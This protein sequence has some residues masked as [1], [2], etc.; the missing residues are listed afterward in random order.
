MEY[1]MD[2]LQNKPA[3]LKN[4][5][6]GNVEFASEGKAWNRLIAGNAKMFS[7][8]RVDDKE[9]TYLGANL[10]LVI[11]D[12][13]PHTS[14]VI[15]EGTYGAPDSKM[16]CMSFDGDKPA[17]FV[18]HPFA[19]SCKSCPKA[20]Y[21]SYNEDGKQGIACRQHKN[22]VVAKE[23][24]L[25]ELF[26]M[27]A[28]NKSTNNTKYNPNQQSLSEYVKQLTGFQTGL[29]TV[30]T[31]I[32]FKQ[33]DAKGKPLN[34]PVLEF[35]PRRYLKETEIATIK[36]HIDSGITKEM[37]GLTDE[38]FKGDITEPVAE[39]IPATFNAPG[40]ANVV[41]AP[42]VAEA[43]VAPAPKVSAKK[44][45]QVVAPVEDVEAA[46]QSFLDDLDAI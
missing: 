1:K 31:G 22:L 15:Y 39:E 28:N 24:N 36:A 4:E 42:P 45:E 30:V 38:G 19:S 27:K 41:T 44:K 29:H 7:I 14:R 35:S 20:A 21:G 3:Y 9:E 34:F 25:D 26:V 12:V 17:S 46:K 2:F 6:M 23:D 8:K 10:D 16:R 11:V 5:T 18:Q 43:E 40:A 33:F 13:T 37:L 32:T